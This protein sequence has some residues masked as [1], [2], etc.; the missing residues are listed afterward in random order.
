[1]RI[2]YVTI[3]VAPEIMQGGV[4]KKIRSQMSI[5][6]EQ[7]QAVTLFSL[8]PARIP[9][10]DERQFVFD[11]RVNLLKREINRAS[12]LKRMLVSIRQY[13]P[14]MIYL[15]Y[16]LYSFPL[17]HIFNIAP[18]VLE[19]NS[20]DKVEYATRGKFFYWMNCLTRNLIFAS[21]SGIIPPTRELISAFP[22]KYNKPV[23][24]ISNGI[25][26]SDVELLPPTNNTSPVITMVASPGMNWHG[27]DKLIKLAE[28]YPDLT[29]NIVGYSLRD[30]GSIT[31]GNVYFHGLLYGKELSEVLSRTD[32]TCGTLALHRKKMNEAS[33]LKV[34]ESLAFGIPVIIAY[35]DTDLDELEL[36]TILRIPNTEMNIIENAERI[37]KFAYKMIGKRVNID[38]VAPYIDQRKKEEARLVFFESIIAG[39]GA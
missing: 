26:L 23:V 12:A 38:V 32:V 9:F 22:S 5:W 3:H 35:K 4:G 1:M 20:N 2:A 28:L 27:V 11:S 18:V 17:H 16:G 30:V 33:P 29:V 37:R 31:S 34:R 6:R 13:K 15:R 14:D 10:P 7:G 8:T 21:V 36:D 39:H 25:D 19:I 24:V